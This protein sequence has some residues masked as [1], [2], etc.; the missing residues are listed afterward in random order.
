M[1]YR[2]ADG[3]RAGSGRDAAAAAAVL[4][5]LASRQQACMMYTIGVFTVK[6]S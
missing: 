4:I 1:S 3:L 6:N 2:F 5:L